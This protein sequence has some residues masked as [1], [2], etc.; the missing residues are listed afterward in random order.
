MTPH[1]DNPTCEDAGDGWVLDDRDCDDADPDVNADAGEVCDEIDNDCDGSVDV[2]SSGG[3]ICGCE[4]VSVEEDSETDCT[5]GL[6]ND[7]NGA[8]DLDDQVCAGTGEQRQLLLPVSDNYFCRF[9]AH[10]S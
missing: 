10:L 5:D 6:D 3:S 2:D 8:T 1:P 4:G 7:C 9:A